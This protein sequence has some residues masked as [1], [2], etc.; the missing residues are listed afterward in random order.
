MKLLLILSLSIFPFLTNSQSLY[1]PNIGDGAKNPRA[2]F[3]YL[4][5]FPLEVRAQQIDTMYCDNGHLDRIENQ[6]F[7]C[8]VIPKQEG[9][10]TVTLI[11]SNQGRKDTTTTTITVVKRP[12]LRLVVHQ[13]G[14]AFKLNLLDENDKVVSKD[15]NSF[16]EVD[17]FNATTNELVE[18]IHEN[19]QKPILL[20][21]FISEEEKSKIGRLTFSTG[22][23]YNRTY[24]LYTGNYSCSMKLK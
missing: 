1:F 9:I 10:L 20:N 7:D 3:G 15:Y 2:Q 5:G 13:D 24:D 16:I 23:V 6:S 22:A 14:D 12:L 21:N 8:M 11:S 18:S 4:E 17:L 19:W